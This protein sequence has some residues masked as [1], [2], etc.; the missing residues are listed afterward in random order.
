MVNI[1]SQLQSTVEMFSE[2]A[3][4]MSLAVFIM[5]MTSLVKG[6]FEMY[7]PHIALIMGALFG[8][9]IMVIVGGTHILTILTGLV[10]G[11]VFGATAVG[12]HVTAVGKKEE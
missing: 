10:Y 7:T 5:L 6:R 8:I 4:V 12:I 1:L 2:I 3:S 9:L 11:S